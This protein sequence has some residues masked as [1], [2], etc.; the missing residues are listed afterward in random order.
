MI[1]VVTSIL[2]FAPKIIPFLKSKW[3]IIPIIVI[4]GVVLGFSYGYKYR[5]LLAADEQRQL[6]LEYA[7]YINNE[8]RKNN[9]LSQKLEDALKNQKE[10]TKVV[11]KYVTKEIEKPV[12][13][14][15]VVPDSG[16]RTIQESVDG[17][18][19][20]RDASRPR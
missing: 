5:G 12:Y 2:G 8:L 17:F 4:L 7:R 14:E 3:V 6:Q 18:N 9:E 1:P 19:R 16:V 10:T 15:C 13:R 11:T 20:S